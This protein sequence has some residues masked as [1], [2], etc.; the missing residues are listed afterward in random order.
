MRQAWG[1][2]LPA[3]TRWWNGLHLET[4]GDPIQF[5]TEDGTRTFAGSEIIVCATHTGQGIAR[6]MHDDLSTTRPEKR[7]TLLVDPTNSRAYDRYR[8]WGWHK[9][10]WLRPNL[11][12][13]PRFD[14]LI[15]EFTSQ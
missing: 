10:G 5:T 8:R 6:A 12:N 3:D 7:A 13:A 1:W 4:G 11:P 9:V 2:P 15:R 14:V